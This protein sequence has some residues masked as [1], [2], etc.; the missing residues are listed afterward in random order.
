MICA[1]EG[2]A[3]KVE[4]RGWCHK[5]YMRWYKHGDPNLLLRAENGEPARWLIEHVTFEGTDCLIWPFG[6][7][8]KGYAGPVTI[9]GRTALACRFMCEMANGPPP[10]SE[11]EAAHSC[12]KG[13]DSCIHPKHL[14]WATQSENDADKDVH[15]TRTRGIGYASAKLNDDAVRRIRTMAGTQ[16]EI[17]DYFGVSRNAI[18][19]VL[20][21][22][23]WSHVQ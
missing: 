19:Q 10:S 20:D 2:C 23:T 17:A 3:A 7:A 8:G 14:R 1:I 21:G 16:Q 15:G 18:R 12:G 11:H 13:T 9:E 4:C 5:H 22:K 6:R